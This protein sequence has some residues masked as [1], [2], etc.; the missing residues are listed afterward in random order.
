MPRGPAARRSRS[1]SCSVL[2]RVIFAKVKRG[3]E[4]IVRDAREDWLQ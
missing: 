3:C 1:M 2:A 4:T